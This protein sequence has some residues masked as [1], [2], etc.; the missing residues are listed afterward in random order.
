MTPAPTPR[1]QL[2]FFRAIGCVLLFSVAWLWFG[3]EYTKL[4]LFL[5]SPFLPTSVDL[6]QHGQDIQFLVQ[7][8]KD[9]IMDSGINGEGYYWS[10]PLLNGMMMTYGL[11]LSISVMLAVPSLTFR[12][13]YPLISLV[14]FTAFAAHLIGL[15]IVAH[16][17]DSISHSLIARS[18]LAEPNSSEFITTALTGIHSLGRTLGYLWLFIPSLVWLPLLIW[19]WRP[20]RSPS[21]RKVSRCI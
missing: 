6:Q 17:I 20:L 21:L 7:G 3:E 2:F 16:Q 13:R 15:C 8:T 14:V 9:G 12:A 11:I 1:L 18:E 5:T 10:W 4:L 19:L